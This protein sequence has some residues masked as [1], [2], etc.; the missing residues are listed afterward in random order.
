MNGSTYREKS[1]SNERISAPIA[2][3][4]S[5][6]VL[7][8]LAETHG[9]EPEA[10]GLAYLRHLR[11]DLEAISEPRRGP[12]QAG[13]SAVALRIVEGHSEGP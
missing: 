7:A 12:R 9:W 13:G 5:S 2:R 4:T 10:L 6:I 8:V 1:L 11:R 3:N